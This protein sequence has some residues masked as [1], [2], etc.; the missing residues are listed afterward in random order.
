MYL[1]NAPHM[2]YE[3]TYVMLKP[4]SLQRRIVG[5]VLNRIERKGLKITA[6]KMMQIPEE[7]ARRHYAEHDGK[8]FFGDLI[9]Y[10]TAGPVVAMVVAGESAI[11]RVRLL[12]GA[13]KVEEA[14]PGTIRG[15]YAAVTT[16]NIIHASDSQESA[17]REIALFFEKNEIVDWSD[18]NE[19][20][21]I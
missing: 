11:S 8:A 10:I 20:W 7:V 16:K 14:M 6:L 1:H 18:P 21:T 15:D 19:A 5:D 4:G 2:G 17:A 9:E 13:T 12:A 3:Q